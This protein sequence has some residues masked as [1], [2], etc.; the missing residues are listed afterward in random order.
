MLPGRLSG[1]D[2]DVLGADS[3]II[4]KTTYIQALKRRY[5]SLAAAI[6]LSCISIPKP[7]YA[8]E[9]V[10]LAD[11]GEHVEETSSG[12]NAEPADE[13]EEP[14]GGGRDDIDLA[15]P[16]QVFQWMEENLPD[17]L[18]KWESLSA[19][20]WEALLP[21]QVCWDFDIIQDFSVYFLGFTWS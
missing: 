21:S 2:Q 16:E 6:L 7:V 8:S 3:G 17:T 9:L 20:W 19:E 14:A 10:T 5:H 15:D 18:A 11:E 4:V 1:F 12:E 13:T